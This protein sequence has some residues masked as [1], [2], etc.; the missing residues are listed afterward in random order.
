MTPAQKTYIENLSESI[1]GDLNRVGD[2]VGS[3][4]RAD[5]KIEREEIVKIRKALST[6]SYL[7]DALLLK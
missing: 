1:Y 4:V 3:L 7:L 2:I 6:A 5:E